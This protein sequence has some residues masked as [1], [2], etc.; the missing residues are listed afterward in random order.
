MTASW[1]LRVVIVCV[2][3]AGC[4]RSDRVTS[5]GTVTYDGQPV[6]TGMIV[7]RPLDRGT[8]PEAAPISAGRFTISGGLGKRRVEI[9]GTRQIDESTLPKTMP[10]LEGVPLYEDYIP[11]AYNAESTLEVEV[12][13][14]GRNV[15]DFDLETAPPER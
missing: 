10:R 15:F 1:L 7:F 11:S 8:A 13:A 12:A 6:T 9:R 4:Q 5:T 3:V 14:A 2:G